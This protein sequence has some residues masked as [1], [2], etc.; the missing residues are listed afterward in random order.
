LAGKHDFTNDDVVLA[1]DS[2]PAGALRYLAFISFYNTTL[3]EKG[4]KVPAGCGRMQGR[5]SFLLS[6]LKYCP[7]NNTMAFWNLQ[8]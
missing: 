4:F 1:G 2:P 5:D 8:E 6:S 3:S 7:G